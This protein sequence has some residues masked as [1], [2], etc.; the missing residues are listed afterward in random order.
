LRT[1]DATQTAIVAAEAQR[2]SWLFT[3]VSTIPTTYRWAT[4]VRSYGGNAFEYRVKPETFSGLQFNRAKSEAGLQVANTVSFDVVDPGNTLTASDFVDGTVTVELVMSDQGA[5]ETAIVTAKFNV[6]DCRAKYQVLKFICEDF[7]QQHLKGDYPSDKYV[8]DIFPSDDQDQDSDLVVPVPF[9]CAYPPIQSIYVNGDDRYYLLGGSTQL[10]N[11]NQVYSPKEYGPKS[12]W[13][14][15]LDCGL[16]HYLKLDETA[17]VTADDATLWAND[18]TVT[19]GGTTWATGHINNALSFDLTGGQYVD[20]GNGAPLDDLGNAEKCQFGDNT[21]RGFTISFWVNAPIVQSFIYFS[22]FLSKDGGANEIKIVRPVSSNGLGVQ[23]NGTAKT[24]VLVPNPYDT[25][26]HMMT[27]TFAYNESDDWVV[28]PYVDTNAIASQTWVAEGVDISNTGSLYWG[29][30]PI[31][32]ACNSDL[33][34]CRIYNRVLTTTDISRLYAYTAS[35]FHTFTQSSK[36]DGTENWKVC[37]LTIADSDNDGVADANGLWRKSGPFLPPA[38]SLSRDD[39]YNIVKPGDVIETV[40]EDMGVDTGDIDTGAAST[41]ETANDTFDSWGLEFHGAYVYKRPRIKII[42][43]LLN[44]CHSTLDITDKIE[45]RVLSKTSQKTITKAEVIKESVKNTGKEKVKMIGTF[46][47]YSLS[48][49]VSDSGYIQ[50]QEWGKPQDRWQK[51]LVPVKATTAN[52][53]KETLELPFVHGSVLA[54]QLGTLYFQKKFLPKSGVAMKLKPSCLALQPDDVITVNHADYGGS[55]AVLIDSIVINHDCSMSIKCIRFSAALDDIGDLAPSAITINTDDTNNYEVWQPSFSGP[56]GIL[57][58]V[59]L[60]ARAADKPYLT[61]SP[62][63]GAAMFETIQEAIDQVPAGGARIYLMNGTHTQTDILTLPNKNIRITGES[64][65]GVIVVGV[66]GTSKYVFD[67]DDVTKD[68]MFDNFTIESG[69]TTT[70]TA[71][72][73]H[74]TG[75]TSASNTANVIIKDISFNPWLKADKTTGDQAIGVEDTSGIIEISNCLTSSVFRFV[76]GA[77][78]HGSITVEGC[79]ITNAVNGILFFNGRID[80]LS[81]IN[82]EFIDC[83]NFSISCNTITGSNTKQMQISGNSIS[84]DETTAHDISGIIVYNCINA[85]VFGNT[86]KIVFEENYKLTAINLDTVKNCVANSNVLDCDITT[87]SETI[88]IN[89]EDSSDCVVSS[90]P[91]TIDSSNITSYHYGVRV[92]GSDRNVIEGNNID[93]TYNSTSDIGIYLSSDTNHNQGT[94][95]ITYLVGTSV[96]DNGSTNIVT[97]N[98]SS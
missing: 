89:I 69:S 41:F 62:T 93:G 92:V 18:G 90:N 60:W 47:T 56:G 27:L 81:I 13:E 7:A 71:G 98:D 59:N 73:I 82:N 15:G 40:L 50:W 63:S 31:L 42:S 64:R 45:L 95:N 80:R 61:V 26:W 20:C 30:A 17:G 22:S 68:Y 55:Y 96:S 44:Q 3:V 77:G 66:G 87:T 36:S 67:L 54:Q 76:V 49:P 48:Q 34:E 70:S 23:I 91:I 37:Q 19:G 83:W 88:M 46:S 11:L 12:D 86:M 85:N 74:I 72:L 1:F 53:S 21:S 35:D 58:N 4:E 51:S 8:R 16:I 43:N 97:A 57:D 75:T 29:G 33:D 5:N 28:T 39:T 25:T 14:S 32:P 78:L 84:Y 38:I 79:V 6:L 94:N 9:G 65:G 10:F 2:A 24:F 52:I